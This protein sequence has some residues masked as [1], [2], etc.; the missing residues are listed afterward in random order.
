MREQARAILAN[1]EEFLQERKGAYACGSADSAFIKFDIFEKL[2]LD[3]AQNLYG[4]DEGSVR[5]LTLKVFEQLNARDH[6]FD[7]H[8]SVSDRFDV[9]PEI[10]KRNQGEVSFYAEQRRMGLKCHA[11]IFVREHL[12]L[13]VS[14]SVLMLSLLYKVR[15]WQTSR[16]VAQ[17][18]K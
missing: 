8:W 18:S 3:G 4:A 14:C 9:D 17:V 7:I 1:F 2:L 10:T 16:S 11:K 15:S 6:E 13:I 12:I 5:A